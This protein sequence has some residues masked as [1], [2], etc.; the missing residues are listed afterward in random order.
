VIGDGIFLGDGRQELEVV[1]QV[2]GALSAWRW[3]QDGGWTDLL[4]PADSGA[5]A[6]GDA[7]GLACFPL[8]PYSNRIRAGRFRFA[9]RQIALPLNLGDHPHSIHGHGWQSP[10]TVVE[11]GDCRVVLG[12]AHAADAW[13]Y[14]YDARQEIALGAEG[15]SVSLVLSNRSDRPMPAGLGL[16]PYFAGAR[17]A[18]LTA[19][20][21]GV[22]LADAEVMPTELVVPP[23]AEW[24][25]ARG[26]AVAGLGCDNVFTGW[27]G[28]ARVERPDVGLAIELSAGPPLGFLVVYAPEGRDF[29]CVEPVSHMTDA[30]NLAAEGRDDTGMQVL[31]QGESL[32]ASVKLS[33]R[34]L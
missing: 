24:D 22:W 23:P 10:W 32:T 6:A 34:G 14:A 30:F 26:R 8:V 21:T 2:G 9:G 7:G 28:R 25:L 33:V 16:H 5:V 18:R 3:R 4:R 27:D 19:G 17:R 13:P 20:V 1:P 12:Y 31:A 29:F 11:Q 15:V